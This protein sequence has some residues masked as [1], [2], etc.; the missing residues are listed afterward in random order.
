MLVL[1]LSASAARAATYVEE[2]ALGHWNMGA[3]V[4]GGSTVSADEAPVPLG[5]AG[6]TTGT[7]YTWE[8]GLALMACGGFTVRAADDARSAFA[9]ASTASVR[10]WSLGL[11]ARWTPWPRL[12]VAPFVELGV[13]SV[14]L[15]TDDAAAQ[16]GILSSKLGVRVRLDGFE[17]WIAASAEELIVRSSV[18]KNRSLRAGL[19]AGIVVDL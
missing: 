12:E 6:V 2:P 7:G 17:P 14:W 4:Y 1:A 5:V 3:G 9:G 10:E 11:A 18:E 8:S 15:R 19:A 16:G 13:H